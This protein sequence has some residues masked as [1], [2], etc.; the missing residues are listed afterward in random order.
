MRKTI[1]RLFLNMKAVA[2][3]PMLWMTLASMILICVIIAG[4]TPEREDVR[5]GITSEADEDL[6]DALMAGLEGREYE[7]SLYDDRE[8]L[9]QAVTGGSVDYGFAVGADVKDQVKD[10]DTDRTV[11]FITTPFAL[12]GEVVKESFAQSYLAAV[13]E[14]MIENEAY[15]VFEDA[16]DELTQ[17][18]KEKNRQYLDSDL[19]FDINIIRSEND[20]RATAPDHIDPDQNKGTYGC[21]YAVI[22]VAV[23]LSVFALYGRRYRGGLK[24]ILGCMDKRERMSQTVSFLSAAALPSAVTGFVLCVILMDGV[25]ISD[26]LLKLILLVIY[27]IV[28]TCAVGALI[29]RNDT[30]SALIPVVTGLQIVFCFVYIGMGERLPVLS[31]IRFLLPVGVLL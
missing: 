4:I 26:L 7:I 21:I 13:S 31:V 2:K 18:L 23:F 28:W 17:R 6:T 16:D 11:T 8:A 14:Y 27:S 19:L 22:A 1:G 5:V 12:Y 20:T 25:N 15:S 30:Y 9:E 3:A 29:R 10:G 24:A